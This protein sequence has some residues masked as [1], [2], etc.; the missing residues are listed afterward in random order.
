MK[1][2]ALTA[3]SMLKKVFRS[4][5]RSLSRNELG[6]RLQETYAL[7]WVYGKTVEKVIEEALSDQLSP[8]REGGSHAVIEM[9]PL[10]QD[11]LAEELLRYLQECKTPISAEQGLKRLRRKGLISYSFS[12][13]KLPLFRDPR[14]IRFHGSELWYLAS[15][16]PAN[17]RIYSFLV[18][19]GIKQLPLNQLYLMMDSEMGLP[20]KEY[21]FVLEGDSRFQ[22]VDGNFVIV[23]YKRVDDMAQMETAVDIQKEENKKN[24]E[25]AAA[26][27]NQVQSQDVY[28]S[29]LE[30]I[31]SATER[32]EQRLREMEEEVLLFFKENNM[33]SIGQLVN[34]KEKCENITR[35]LEEIMELL[36][37]K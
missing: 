2:L 26:M 27:V 13:E 20:R 34:E 33:N 35:K 8:F 4:G 9:S 22:V 3:S 37:G 18:D 36:Y 14:F 21:V 25:V 32:L 6:Y 28:E 10:G 16:T 19:K 5:E 24:E 30:D 29:V 1:E 17:D 7:E 23:S 12:S 11:P 15:W 31:N